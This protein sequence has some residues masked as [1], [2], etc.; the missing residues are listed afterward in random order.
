MGIFKKYSAED[1]RDEL[2]KLLDEGETTVAAIYCAFA[3]GAVGRTTS[4]G[5][6]AVT[7]RRRIIGVKFELFGKTAFSYSADNMV[8]ASFHRAIAGYS[9]DMTFMNNGKKEKLMFM[10]ARKVITSFPDQEANLER[11]KEEI[12]VLANLLQ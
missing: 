11:L 7:D 9:A 12:E 4:S 1:M 8:K 10:A 5:Y 6:V 2:S 3:T